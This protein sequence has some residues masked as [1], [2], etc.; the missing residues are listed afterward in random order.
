[1][2]TIRICSFIG[3]KT[4]LSRRKLRAHSTLTSTRHYNGPDEII[5]MPFIY[6]QFSAVN[7][8]KIKQFVKGGKIYRFPDHVTEYEEA[9]RFCEEEG[10]RLAKVTNIILTNDRDDPFYQFL[11]QEYVF[12]IG[13]SDR[14]NEGEW[15]WNDG[16][17]CLII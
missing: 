15:K 6:V 7:C 11:D 16:R 12:W 9:E 10:G 1:M 5:K 4:A 8:V 14:D 2:S 3:R 17:V 13:M